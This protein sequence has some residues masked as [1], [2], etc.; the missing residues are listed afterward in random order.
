[1]W[2]RPAS[3]TG[4]RFALVAGLGKRSNHIAIARR[5][6]SLIGAS[7]WAATSR[8]RF[9]IGSGNKICTLCM[10]TFYRWNARNQVSVTDP[11]YLLDGKAE[12]WEVG[13]MKTTIDLPD[14][15]FR[16]AKA[17]AA[18]QGVSLK[19]FITQAVES[20]LDESPKDWRQAIA[21]LPRVDRET[22]DAVLRSVAEWDAIDLEFQK[23]QG[24][25][26]R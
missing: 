8:R 17:T 16:R 15:I 19:W 26:N 7:S 11:K 3:T 14:P 24:A 9:I 18:V 21:D 5:M 1:M 25:T 6:I 23:K 12:K 2:Q 13:T 10:D 22:S 4:T 20:R